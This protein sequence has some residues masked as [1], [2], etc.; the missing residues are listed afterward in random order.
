VGKVDWKK[1]RY[2]QQEFIQAWL[3]SKTIG[4]VAKKLG[5]NHSGGGYVVLKAAAQQLNLPTNHM[6]EYGV[7]TGPAYNHIKFIPLPEILVE[8]STYTNIA[9]LKIRLLREGLLENKCYAEGCGLTEWRGKP[10]S[11]QLDHVNGNNFDHRIENLRLLCPNCH[12]QTDTFAGKNK[13]R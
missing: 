7:N 11:L 5:R 10:I 9:R 13:G 6:I 2:T 8:N 4:E 12:S 1:R 3:S